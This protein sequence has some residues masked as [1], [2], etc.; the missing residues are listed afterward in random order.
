M[1]SVLKGM[2]LCSVL[3]AMLLLGISSAVNG[4]HKRGH[5]Q[6]VVGEIG[7]STYPLCDTQDQIEQI[8]EAGQKSFFNLLGT[9]TSLW[10]EKNDRNEPLCALPDKGKHWVFYPLK[11]VNVFHGVQVYNGDRHTVYILHIRSVSG[12]SEYYLMSTW[13]LVEPRQKGERI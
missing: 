4:Y 5:N 6:F 11:Q 3:V 10:M 13:P 12:E 1:N 7:R 9:Y 8:V 2:L